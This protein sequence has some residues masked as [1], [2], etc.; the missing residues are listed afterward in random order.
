LGFSLVV[1]QGPY[2]KNGANRMHFHFTLLT[3]HEHTHT[4]AHTHTQ[5][6][7]LPYPQLS[8]HMS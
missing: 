7:D 6:P 2:A 1:S 4:H 8:W 5:T 3:K